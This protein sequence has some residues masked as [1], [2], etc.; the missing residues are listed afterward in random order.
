MS[1]SYTLEPV[2]KGKVVLRTTLGDIEIELWAKEAPK[3]CRNFVQL[4]LEGFYDNCPFHRVV[5][6]EFT[7]TW[8]FNKPLYLAISARVCKATL[9]ASHIQVCAHVSQSAA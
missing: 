8:R 5:N 6:R 7:K 2:T 1:T 3:A 4:A 9:P